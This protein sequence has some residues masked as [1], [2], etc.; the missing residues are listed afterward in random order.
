MSLT[1]VPLGTN[2]FIPTHGRH[3]M[4][5]L[6]LGGDAPLLLDAG[7]GVGRLLEAPVARLLEGE[8]R[9]D[10][11]LT[12][13]H[14]DHVVGLSYLPGVWRGRTVR[15]Y[16][17]APPLVDGEPEDALSR[18]LG[19]PLFPNTLGEL[20][21]GVEVVPYRDRLLTAAGWPLRLRRQRHGGGSVGLVLADRL[22]YLTDCEMEEESAASF[23]QGVSVLLHDTWVTEAEVE[24][25]A[26]RHGHSTLEEVASLARRAGVGTLVPVHHRPDRTGQDL[27]RMATRLRKLAGKKVAVALAQEGATM[28]IGSRS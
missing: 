3:T 23:V 15:L 4:S 19:P 22:A 21:L 6:V 8:E 20:P 9:L 18:L 2:G 11:L 17:P 24:A 27:E 7:T 1:L 16:A 25:G 14:L 5:F 10:L 12:H 26:P 28:E 13:Y